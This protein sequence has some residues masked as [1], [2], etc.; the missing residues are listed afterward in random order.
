MDIHIEEYRNTILVQ[1]KWKYN[2][3]AATGLT[4][5][6]YIEKKQFHNQVDGLIW[7]NWGSKFDL[8]VTGSSDFATQ[9]VDSVFTVN[10]DI[11]WVLNGEHW[12]VNATKIT[13]GSQI[14]S[15][16]SWGSRCINLDTEDVVKRHFADAG[17]SSYQYPVVHEF[18]HGTGN[19]IYASTGMHGDEYKSSSVY[20]IDKPSVMNH[21]NEL[22]QR[23]LDYL[24]SQ[25]NQM[26]SNTTFYVH[27]IN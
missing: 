6:T 12:T 19:S 23:H 22:R 5:W 27:T 2:W 10:F 4:P 7:G 13:P 26:L 20:Y 11:K 3:I 18:G 8:K 9:H 15:S 1:Q 24:L 17:V 21:G 25:L 16:L 14:T